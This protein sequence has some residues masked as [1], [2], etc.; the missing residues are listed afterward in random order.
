[1]RIPIPAVLSYTRDARVSASKII[2]DYIL[3]PSVYIV[4]SRKHRPVRSK[5]YAWATNGFRQK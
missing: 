3:W 4:M 1:M 2:A 5:K